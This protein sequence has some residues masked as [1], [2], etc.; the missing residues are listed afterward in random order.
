MNELQNN[1][2]TW[3]CAL[4]F[5]IAFALRMAQPD[6]VEFKR[7]EATVARL[8]QAIA[9]EGYRPAVGVDSSVGIDN[10][11][12]TLYLMAFPCASNPDPL[13]A[14]VFTTFLNA[15]AVVVCYWLTQRTFGPLQH[16]WRR[17][18]LLSIP[19]AVLYARKIWCRT[20]PLFTLG[21]MISNIAVFVWGKRWALS[22]CLCQFGC[23]DR[24]AIGGYCLY[25]G[26]FIRSAFVSG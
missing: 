1:L 9:Y 10:L 22:G 14:V 24:F 15:S 19:W 13:S 21:F 4:I 17:R 23:S 2:S 11:P 18:Y 25:P 26:V 8:G 5:V 20:L 16:C 3:L 6:L 7:D 12:L